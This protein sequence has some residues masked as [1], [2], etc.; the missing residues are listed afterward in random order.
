MTP[1]TLKLNAHQTLTYY[2]PEDVATMQAEITALK[3]AKRGSAKVAALYVIDGQYVT[4]AQVAE[5][6]RAL[7]A[8]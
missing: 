6:I 5:R 3:S 7:V 1:R 4:A 8:P 2:T